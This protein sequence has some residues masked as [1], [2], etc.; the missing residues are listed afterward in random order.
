[1]SD[2]WLQ[3]VDLCR[4]YRRGDNEVRAVDSANISLAQ[5]EFLA[6]VGSSGSGKSTLMNL[7]A[8]LDSPTSGR[9]EV[10]GKALSDLSRRELSAYRAHMVG[11]VFQSFNLLPH[12]TAIENVELA[13]YF[14]DTPR[15]E[16]R[17]RSEEILLRLGLADRL[18]HKPSDLSGGEQ[19]RVALARALVKKPKILLADEATGNL[20][21]ENT[22]LIANLL[23]EL[24]TDG[25]SVVLVTH[26]LDLAHQIAGRTIRLNYGR[27]VTENG[28]EVS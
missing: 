21:H 5:G 18:D 15:A 13:L 9:V 28:P 24:N 12:R 1:M 27:I 2:Q 17:E 23:T 20:D 7:I 16:R 19:Q 4:W 14:N 3:T 6:I 11:M 26:D 25:L 10:E 22:Q 8:G